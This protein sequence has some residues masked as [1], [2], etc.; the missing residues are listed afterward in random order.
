ML[1]S[2]HATNAD[3]DER[4]A[5][6]L[7]HVQWHGSLE[8]YLNVLSIFYEEAECKYQREAQPEI[9]AGADPIFMTL[10]EIPAYKEERCVGNGFIKLTGMAWLIVYLSEDEC[11]WHICHLTYYLGIHEVAQSNEASRDR[12]GDGNIVEHMP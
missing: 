11:P 10:I 7:P 6:K 5:E 4:D 3:D 12:R 1:F 8:S 9:E 2:H